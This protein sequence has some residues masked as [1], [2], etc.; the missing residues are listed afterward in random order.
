VAL[1]VAACGK[2][3]AP[4]SGSPDMAIGTSADLATDT[5]GGDDLATVGG[6]DMA[7][8][9]GLSWPPAQSFPTF[10]PLDTLDVI[11]LEAAANDQKT[12]F[13]TLAGLINRTRP[14]IYTVQSGDDN[15]WLGKLNATTNTVA[16]PF[17]LLA[18]YK[19]EITGI[20]IF[21]DT[22]MDTIDLATTIA[23]VK[24][25]I[26]AAPTLAAKLGAAPYSFTVIADLRTNHFADKLAVYQYELDHFAAMATHRLICGLNPSIAGMLR[27]YCVA[28]GAMTVWLDPTNAAE[29]AMLGNFLKLLEVNSPY[30]GWWV[31][32]PNG[33]AAASS[34]SVPVY[35]A[36]FSQNLTVLGGAPRGINV[37][38]AA[39]KPPLQNK[40]YVA[41][42][43][44]DGDNLQEDQHLIARKWVDPNRGK[45]PIAWTIDPALVDV[46]P[47]IMNYFW[48]TATAND[49]LVS[50][51]SG[52]G[53]TYPPDWPGNTFA[54]YAKRSAA[55][56]GAAGLR[57]ITVWSNGADIATAV[58]DDYAQNMPHV[59]GLT[60]QQQS[61]SFKVLNG[62]LP[63][64]KFADGAGYAGT[65]ADL[66]GG[67]DK[68]AAGWNKTSPLFIAVQGDM[69]QQVITPTA[70]YN[71]Q[72]NYA[73][74]ADYV[75]VR[76]DHFFQLIREANKLTIDP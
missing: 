45:V 27:D 23:G 4:H 13:V 5:S 74:N 71:V 67:I 66:I 1:L 72:Q 56:L 15:T 51:P 62:T 39:T 10:A 48:S 2:D 49:V 50:G 47:T 55:Y 20:V 65:Q 19:S 59:L 63:M 52:L 6:S 76:A 7:V 34:Y 41:V 21:D 58:A 64:L 42:F 9:L 54:E 75:F 37:P 8:R 32:E 24:N 69:N 36:D 43:M 40:I 28:L 35:A 11:D 33:V 22:Q 30:M 18:K 70:F 73:G 61:S 38:K 12:L 16:D 3:K 25:G 57:V 68:A 26:V 31:N 17:S 29:K 14:R 53:Y 60:I 44:S 46:A